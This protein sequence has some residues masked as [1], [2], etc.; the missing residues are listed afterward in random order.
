[1]TSLKAA[2]VLFVAT[3]SV[4]GVP[5]IVLAQAPGADPHHPA[6]AAPGATQAP[7]GSPSTPTPGAQTTQPGGM[8]SGMMG[9]MH[10]MRSGM[11]GRE[12]MGGHGHMMKIMIAIADADRDGALSFEEISA[13]HRRIFDAVDTDKN[14]KVTAEEMRAFMAP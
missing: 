2:A 3:M 8:G 10:G 1:M 9:M 4:A 13:I 14:G 11:P 7:P 5:E 6:T 12:A